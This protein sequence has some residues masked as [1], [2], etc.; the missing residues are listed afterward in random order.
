MAEEEIEY[1]ESS[2]AKITSNVISNLIAAGLIDPNKKKKKRINWEKNI[3]YEY[4]QTYFRDFPYWLRIEVG[5]IPPGP[6]GVYYAKTRRW[7][8]C[9]I[10]MPDHLLVIE[11]KMKAEPQVVSQL[12]NYQ[13]LVKETPLF[14]RWKDLPVKIK[15]VCAMIDD[16]THRFI[17]S[18]G[19]DVEVFKPSNFD[20]WFKK[21]ILRQ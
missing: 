13:M 11:F 1:V 5:A 8:D 12:L 14:S 9:V 4:I 7:A 17:E 10:R 18:Q 6:D 20:E 15:I 19:I 16:T 21:K 2:E 3:A